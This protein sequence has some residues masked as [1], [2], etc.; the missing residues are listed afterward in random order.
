MVCS[1]AAAPGQ[2]Q[3]ERDNSKTSCHDFP[4][5]FHAKTSIGWVGMCAISN[6]RPDQIFWRLRAFILVVLTLPSPASFGAETSTAK[7][8]TAF[9][10][11][12]K[13]TETFKTTRRQYTASPT[14]L[15]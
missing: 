5:W 7:I 12:A 8:E 6:S 14:N 2:D 4:V 3:G 9:N 15:V 1:N 10:F 11:A 13:A